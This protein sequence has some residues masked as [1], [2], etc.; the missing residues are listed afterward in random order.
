[1]GMT[2]PPPWCRFL[3]RTGGTLAV[4]CA[5]PVWNENAIGLILK[6]QAEQSY[7]YIL[8]GEIK[9]MMKM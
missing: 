1:V 8:Y 3:V 7:I 6:K 2:W 9:I 4:M 5:T